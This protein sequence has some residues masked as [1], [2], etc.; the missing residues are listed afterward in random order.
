MSEICLPVHGNKGVGVDLCTH[1]IWRKIMYAGFNLELK[2]INLEQYAATGNEI[3]NKQKNNVEQELDSFLNLDGSLDASEIENVWFPKIK[4][5]VFL[6]HSSKDLENTIALAGFLY[7]EGGVT[8]FIDSC[9][10]DYCD[11]LLRQLDKK[12]CANRDSQG[13][14]ISYRYKDRNQSTSHVHM[15]LNG[16]LLKMI[17]CSESVIF[18]NTPHS[19]KPQDVTDRYKTASPWIYSELL[20]TKIVEKKVPEGKEV[21][22]RNSGMYESVQINVEYDAELTHLYSLSYDDLLKA[23]SN[24]KQCGFDNCLNYLYKCVGLE[25]LIKR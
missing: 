15:I 21:Y 24:Y 11:K 4:T 7:K 10:W 23:T 2:S 19:I 1:F 3:F 5:D 20:M 13:K 22:R 6:S 17:D 8:S 12:W 18:V 25:E 16:A 14:I 9:V